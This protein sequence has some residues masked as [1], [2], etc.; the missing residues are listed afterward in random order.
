MEN[1]VVGNDVGRQDDEDDE[2]VKAATDRVRDLRGRR[3]SARSITP[4]LTVS[5]LLDWIPLKSLHSLALLPI[6]LDRGTSKQFISKY[7]PSPS[8]TLPTFLSIGFLY[9]C[10]KCLLWCGP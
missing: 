8:I 7:S 5:P 3:G 9:I 1:A 6:T 10:A 2:A 4:L